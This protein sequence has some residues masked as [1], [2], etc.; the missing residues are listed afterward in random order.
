MHLIEKVKWPKISLLVGLI[1]IALAIL[2]VPGVQTVMPAAPAA[3]LAFL[4]R[5]IITFGLH[6]LM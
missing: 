3:R 4:I 6:Q 5:V 1:S 2:V